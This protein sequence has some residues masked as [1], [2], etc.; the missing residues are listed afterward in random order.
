MYH[1][2]LQLNVFSCRSKG[3][4]FHI[5]VWCFWFN[6]FS[7]ILSRSMSAWWNWDSM[8][9]IDLILSATLRFSIVRSEGSLKGSILETSASLESGSSFSRGSGNKS[10]VCFTGLGN[11][12][13]WTVLGERAH[14]I[15]SAPATADLSAGLPV[16]IRPR[17]MPE[18]PWSVFPSI[19]RDFFLIIVPLIFLIHLGLLLI[20]LGY[21]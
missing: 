16:M 10:P 13:P 3:S 4:I 19:R 14:C 12:E 11:A 15:S 20:M 17:L 8:L 6:H 7:S 5:W 2:F 18:S 21:L 1:I 9:G